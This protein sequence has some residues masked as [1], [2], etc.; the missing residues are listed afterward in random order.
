MYT[1][2]VRLIEL[3]ELKELIVD[4]LKLPGEEVGWNRVKR[5]GAGRNAAE[6]SGTS[7]GTSA[8]GSPVV[9]VP[10]CK[11]TRALGSAVPPRKERPHALR[12]SDPVQ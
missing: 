7:I 11:P 2:E 6:R 12:S 1:V 3:T 8:T 4:K 5:S 10:T 9:H